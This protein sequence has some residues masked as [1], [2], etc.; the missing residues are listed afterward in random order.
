MF[1]K[2]QGKGQAHF[3]FLIPFPCIF[4]QAVAARGAVIQA[5]LST[6]SF[7]ISRKL[8]VWYLF[9]QD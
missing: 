6:K 9:V 2:V 1:S 4:C 3:P 5:C 7:K 8:I